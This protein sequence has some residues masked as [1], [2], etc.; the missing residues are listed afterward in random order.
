MSLGAVPWSGLIQG[1]TEARD[2]W[3]GAE[4]GLEMADALTRALARREPA[5]P[6]VQTDDG[7]AVL[8]R[9][10]AVEHSII[11]VELAE[12]PPSPA[13]PVAF[14][15]PERRRDAIATTLRWLDV[16]VR[17]YVAAELTVEAL[18]DAAI[19]LLGVA[20]VARA[21][22][23]LLE[24]VTKTPVLNLTYEVVIDRWYDLEVVIVREARRVR[25]VALEKQKE[26]AAARQAR[27][28]ELSNATANLLTIL[29]KERQDIAAAVDRVNAALEAHAGLV[30]ERD[31]VEVELRHISE[32]RRANDEA[33][34]VAGTKLRAVR[35][36]INNRRDA[37]ERLDDALDA[38]E[39]AHATP[40]ERAPEGK[41]CPNGNSWDQ[42]NNDAH[43]PYKHAF[44]E[45]KA[46]LWDDIKEARRRLREQH[47]ALE[48]DR[49][50]EA[51]LSARLQALATEEAALLQKERDARALRARLAHE[52]DAQYRRNLAEVSFLRLVLD[53]RGNQTDTARVSAHQTTLGEP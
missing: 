5:L 37:I 25:S 4:H 28:I 23:D 12:L 16:A 45:W 41:R 27:R 32:A 13:D 47:D 3:T 1:F 2:A 6:S 18:G 21:T 52:I 8:E 49:A 33:R 15:D 46:R 26:L 39:D 30:H 34:T 20:D 38:L 50:Q 9:I 10:Q 51:E 11:A 31:A 19:Q 53:D 48:R 7:A 24:R 44:T 35:S 17:D 22:A 29:Q 36:A 42:C 43:V 40:Y 14:G